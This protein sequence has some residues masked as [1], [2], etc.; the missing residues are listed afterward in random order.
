MKERTHIYLVRHGEVKNPKKLFYGRLPYFGLNKRGRLQVEKLAEF[1]KNTKVGAIYA[2]PL[3]RSR[4]TAQALHRYHPKVKIHFSKLLLEWRNPLWEGNNYYNRNSKLVDIYR[5][6]PTKLHIPGAEKMYDIE[7]RMVRKISNIMK[8]HHGEN[9]VI[10]SHGDPIRIAGLH[11]KNE[12]LDDLH[13]KACTN[14]S[15]TTLVFN[16]GKLIQS[17]Y[18]EIHPR[19]EETFWTKT[20]KELA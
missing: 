8:S 6:T 5:E 13:N 9:V 7:K 15:I 4:Q 20:R 12:S 19:A 18:K 3:L 17:D 1:F 16:G 10:V 11:Y 14:A 2:S